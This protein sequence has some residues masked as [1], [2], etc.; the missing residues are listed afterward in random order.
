MP[1]NI[2][3]FSLWIWIWILSFLYYFD[4]ITLSPL[5]LS[6]GAVFFTIPHI[7]YYKHHSLLMSLFIIILEIGILLLNLYKH[8]L[9]D[10]KRFF[11]ARDIKKNVIIFGC[12]LLFLRVINKS[13]Y[14]LY[15]I[16]LVE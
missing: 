16:D 11:V 3:A 10:K 2:Y 7:I 4:I 9:I 5:Y 6:I 8:L 13:F 15:F 12:Y 14:K 1:N